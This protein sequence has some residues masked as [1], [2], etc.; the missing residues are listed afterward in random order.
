[1]A[2][3]QTTV[4]KAVVK[5]LEE[6]LP[7]L[8][9]LYPMEQLIEAF[10]YVPSHKIKLWPLLPPPRKEYKPTPQRAVAKGKTQPE[11]EEEQWEDISHLSGIEQ[12][13]EI[14]KRLTPQQLS[15]IKDW[16]LK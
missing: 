8:S 3:K 4:R 12:L 6:P 14:G 2:T 13:M 9:H 5:K 16:P 7:D 10:K 1:M 15:K 11:N